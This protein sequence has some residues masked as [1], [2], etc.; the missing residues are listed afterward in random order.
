MTQNK[1]RFERSSAVNKLKL[2]TSG[3]VVAAAVLLAT[4]PQVAAAQAG[5]TASGH[6]VNGNPNI[7]LG[8]A[9]LTP[10]ATTYI[11]NV[12]SAE[13]VINWTPVDQSGT[14]PI[15][16]LP[17]GNTLQ[18]RGNSAGYTVLNRILPTDSSRA[19]RFDGIVQ[20]R[21]FDGAPTP[22]LQQS[23]N[24]W[25]YSPGG[26]IAGAGSVFDVGSLVLTTNDIDFGDGNL[27]GPN[28]EIRF[29]GAAGSLSSVVVEGATATLA[30]AS[31]DADN[32]FAGS[33]FGDDSYVA[34]VAPRVEQ[35]GSVNADGSVAY[36][37]AEQANL[38]I[39]GNN[40]FS[41]EIP[42]GAGT[43]DANGIVHSGVTGGTAPFENADKHHIYMVAVPKNQ[44]MT[45]LLSGT[46]GH[47]IAA[48]AFIEG[49][50]IILSAGGD[51]SASSFSDSV[52]ETIDPG[53]NASIAITGATFNGSIAAFANND[54]SLNATAGSDVVISLQHAF[55]DIEFTS[56]D[57]ILLSATGGG[58]FDFDSGFDP[59]RPQ[60]ITFNAVNRIDL[61]V[62]PGSRMDMFGNL[63]LNAFSDTQGGVVDLDITGSGVRTIGSGELN[64]DGTFNILAG[65][66]GTTSRGAPVDD[67]TDT[68][69]GTINVDITA[70]GLLDISGG[71]RFGRSIFD[72]SS[73]ANHGSVTG[74]DSFGGTTNLNIVGAGST[75]VAD[76]S[77]GLELEARGNS[78]ST[79]RGS[80]TGGSG[81]GGAVNLTVDGGTITAASLTA[82]AGADGSSNASNNTNESINSA[83]SGDVTATFTDA[84]LNVGQLSLNTGAAAAQSFDA[85]GNVVT[86]N[87]AG[88]DLA[89]TFDNTNFNGNSLGLNGDAF[90]TGNVLNGLVAAGDEGST[91]L[92]IRNGSSL[93]LTGDFNMSGRGSADA[94]GSSGS[95]DLNFLVDNAT[96]SASNITLTNSRTTRAPAGTADGT[97]GDVNFTV[98][99]SGS[100]TAGRLTLAAGAFNSAPGGQATAG[101]VNL[102]VDT[103]GV[104]TLTEITSTSLSISTSGIGSDNDGSTGDTT[105]GLGI[106]GNI[107][108][109]LQGGGTMTMGTADFT[110]DGLI[111]GVFDGQGVEPSGQ[112]GSGV[113][114]SV[115]F[116]LNG[117]TFTAT[118][119]TV[120]A[121]G[122]AS[123]GGNS[124]I[125]DPFLGIIPNVV[126][127][128][129]IGTG[130]DV[131]FNLRGTDVAVNN[132]TVAADGNGGG[133]GDSRETEGNPAGNGGQGIGGSASF[134]ANS[135]S[136]TVANTLTVS[137]GGFG[138][139]GGTGEGVDAGI[140]GNS[141]GGTAIF[142]LD[143]TAVVNA[144]TGGIIVSSNTTGGAGGNAL[145]GNTPSP[146][147]TPAQNSGDGGNAVAG[148]AT[149][150]N[151][152]GTIT[153]DDLN[154]T[155]VGT[156]GAAGQG[157][158]ITIITDPFTGS[159][160]EVFSPSFQG[161]NGAIGGN[162]TG[163]NATVNLNQDDPIARAYT[164][165]A[166]GIGASGSFGINGGDGG[167]GQGGTA[168]LNINN[169]S[170]N[171]S[172]ATIRATATGGAGAVGNGTGG[173]GG[174]GGDAIGGT[175]I[176]DVNGAA[177]ALSSSS[178]VTIIS[179]AAGGAGGA[180]GDN[181]I[182]SGPTG[183]GG[184][185]GDGTGGTIQVS[186]TGGA[187]LNYTADG[188]TN[189]TG[190]GGTGGAG[191][192]SPA[193]NVPGNGGAGGNGSGGNINFSSTGGS[194]FNGSGNSSDSQLS[195]GAVGGAGGLGGTGA[196]GT[197]G[198]T[199]NGGGAAGGNINLTVDGVGSSMI[200]A[201]SLRLDV[202]GV[203]DRTIL[204]SRV[205]YSGG[206]ASGGAVVI[207]VTDGGDFTVNGALAANSAALGGFGDLSSGSATGGNVDI[208]MSGAT[209]N[210]DLLGAFDPSD[211]DFNLQNRS[212]AIQTGDDALT[213]STTASAGDD[214]SGDVSINFTGGTANLGSDVNITTQTTVFGTNGGG[215]AVAGDVDLTFTGG[216]VTVGDITVLAGS[217]AGNGLPGSASGSGSGGN[218]T[219]TNT[220][221]LTIGA[222]NLTSR[223]QSGRAAGGGTAGDAIGGSVSFS[224]D[225]ALNGLTSL[226]LRSD[227]FGNTGQ[228]G[229]ATVDGGEGGSAVSGDIMAS[230][231]GTGSISP[232]DIALISLAIGGLGGAGGVSDG[233]T[234][235]SGANGGA[236]GDATAGNVIFTN[237]RTAD[238]ISDLSLISNA[239]A[240]GGGTGGL[241]DVGGDGGDG[242]QGQGGL[243]RVDL[244]GGGTVLASGAN[245][246]LSAFGFGG[247]GRAG[248]TGTGVT[249]GNGGD[250]GDGIG[251]TAIANLGNDNPNPIL[252]ALDAS[253]T[254][255]AGG[256]GLN[257]GDGGIGTGGL[258]ALNVIDATV[259][260]DDPSIIANGIGGNGGLGSIDPVSGNAGNSGSGGNAIGGTARLEVTG[261]N[262]NID[263]GF[264]DQQSNATGGDGGSG[265]YG[266]LV[267]GSGSGT[268]GDADGGTSEIV[269][270][271]GGTI[272][273]TS[274]LFSLTST[275]TGGQGGDGGGSYADTAADGSNGG[276]GTGGT[277]RLLAQG[278]TISGN[279][280]NITTT[281]QGGDAGIG[282]IYGG[283]GAGTGGPGVTGTG[284]TGI[285]GTATIEVQE[286]SPGIITL[287]NVVATANGTS[288][289]GGPAFAGFGGRIEITDSS[290]DPAGLIT[291]DSLTA[292]AFDTDSGSILFSNSTPL[293]GFYVTGDSGA[294]SVLGE[295]IVNV[296]GNIEYDFDGDSQM[297][298]GGNAVLNSGQNIL[299]NHTNN[300]TPVNSIDVSGTFD[301]NAEFDFIS[302]DG[303]RINSGG[304][305]TVRA[306]QDA[307]VADITGVG[308]VNISALQDVEVNNAAVTGTPFVVTLGT[309]S[310]AAAPQ[311]VINAGFDPTATPLPTYN[312]A[313]GA[314]ITG[315]VTSTGRIDISAGGIA[316]FQG[317]SNVISDN[318]LAVRAGDDIIVEAGAS[319]T[320][321]NAPSTAPNALFT[322]TNPGNL[323]LQTDNFVDIFGTPNAT[324]IGARLT[325][326][327]S[328]VA[329]GDLNAGTF[330]VVM[331]ANAIDGLGGTIN[332]SSFSADIND[333]P[334]NATIAG[335]GQ[336][337]DNG[338][339]SAQCVQG[340]SCFGTITADNIVQIGQNSNND[341]IQAIVEGG[342]IIA[343]IVRITTRN[344]IVMGTDGVATTIRA[345]TEFLAE[346]TE[347]DVNLRDASVSSDSVQ[348]SALNGS[349][350][351][352]GSLASLNSIG[353]D[354]GSSIN[355]AGIT[356]GG[357][358]A[359]TAFGTPGFYSI[360]GTMSVGSLTVGS[361]DINY[362]AG[363]SFIFGSISVPGTD[364]NLVAVGDIDIGSSLTASNINLDGF[365]ITLGSVSANSDINLLAASTIDFG[366]VSA[367]NLLDMTAVNISGD[368]A[369][370]NEVTIFAD[371]DVDANSISA[372][373]T[374]VVEAVNIT[375]GDASGGTVS[376]NGSDIV[377]GGVSG[378]SVDISGDQIS[379]DGAS[380]G[381]LSIGGGDISVGSISADSASLFGDAIFVDSAE[382]GELDIF[383]QT[384]LDVNLIDIDENAT[385]EAAGPMVIGTANTG[386]NASLLA[387]TVTLV[388][389]NVAGDL[390]MEATAG[391]IDGNGIVA[392]G[393]AIDLDATGDIGF[394][395]LSAGTTF[396]ANAGGAITFA[397][398]SAESDL[399]LDAA[400][401]ISGGDASSGAEITIFGTDLELGSLS[402]ESSARFGARDGNIAIDTVDINSSGLFGTATG[403]ITI[404][405]V[406]ASNGIRLEGAGGIEINSATST[407][408]TLISTDGDVAVREDAAF[409]NALTARGNSVFIRSNGSLKTVAQANVGD[410][411]IVTVG[412]LSVDDATAVGNIRLTSLTGSAELNDIITGNA[413]FG[414]SATGI[415]GQAT[416]SSNGNIDVTAALD[417]VINSTTNAANALTITAGNLIDI[418]AL[419]SGTTIDLSS[420]DISINTAGQLGIFDQTNDIFI[421]SN[422]IN[423]AILGGAGTTGVFSLS[424]AEF[425]RIQSNQDLTIFVA[426]TGGS[427]PDLIIQDLTIQTGDNVSGTQIATIGFSGALTI[428]S[429]QSTRVDGNLNLTNASS[430]TTLNL[431][432]V[433]DLR[434]NANGGVI[435]ITDASG[436]FG[437]VGLMTLTA[438]NIYAVT[439]QAFADIAGLDTNAV[440][441]RLE[442][443]DGIDID[444]GLIRGGI[445]QF[446]VDGDLFIQNTAPGVDFADRRGFSV[447]S[448]TISGLSAGSNANIVINGIVNGQTGIDTIFATDTVVGFDD[449]STINGCVIIDPSSCGA[450]PPT[451]TPTPAPTSDPEIDDPVQD[452]IEEEVTPRE[453]G[454]IVS[455]PFETNLIEIK[456]NEEYVDD[457]LIDE[458]VTGAGNDDL[459]VSDEDAS[460]DENDECE[461]GDDSCGE[462]GTVQ[463][464]ELEPAE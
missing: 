432:S 403:T 192:N 242:G 76:G 333:A 85:M 165:D 372:G 140:G 78:T 314:N 115:T 11:V 141:T 356:T 171:L 254:G 384:R 120:S 22:T 213:T 373:D 321:A 376:I 234:G 413:S 441:L 189:A 407:I 59:A 253:G 122:F 136:L 81:T 322:F 267:D 52:D 388:D 66:E 9:S 153:F 167:L 109:T 277:A 181:P 310:I 151:L 451:P 264:I 394:G 453:D 361:G 77:F 402:S 69:G 132:L 158:T 33:S 139:Q 229:A 174:A 378:G 90:G 386:G 24:I 119:L 170:V 452:V 14:D 62:G 414:T 301:A 370:G 348:I 232:T 431:T 72:A 325:P 103:A 285:G 152:S 389:G 237:N 297:T 241:G 101:N 443:N 228:A 269:A 357:E 231:A 380:A 369:D 29:R 1:K 220:G 64:V 7:V 379:I 218:I 426:S 276:Q 105:P 327:S 226:D 201:Q 74:A 147:P 391:D 200:F 127:D 224:S 444:D 448:L 202:R 265:E 222:V 445:A 106:G 148:T 323:V 343:D 292:D 97:P 326:I 342:S 299:I 320:A 337:D 436:S 298:V 464:D 190:I 217:R 364:I 10:G 154:V 425:T 381:N 61:D 223:G 365:D 415:T 87:A 440:D 16:F 199:G 184:A 266:F 307:T 215:N 306:E 291:L 142:N 339:L 455:D 360:T 211:P 390:S 50:K 123:D 44:A 235:A 359:R 304:T 104:L 272:N 178:I 168:S 175:S 411:D 149:F 214:I 385:L 118:D 161:Q 319:L 383:A 186:A 183:A 117:S 91:T 207:A 271:T 462:D 48:T 331:S 18:F 135:G 239:F 169:A 377:I 194:T 240:S 133:G 54:I 336:L 442:N 187:T 256:D 280:V 146:T 188:L 420:A 351:G 164:V 12:N 427:T 102:L 281:G 330:A 83:F 36:V 374:L 206:D 332:A 209:S 408:G 208:S 71:P 282:G 447:D 352:S 393:G 434:I 108:V 278:G 290:T 155:A 156:G 312:R 79:F 328:I 249:P 401:E 243:T 347:G 430:G 84:T 255:A 107:D 128:G 284:G 131:T 274:G 145:V 329:A 305:A 26:I 251:G 367:G 198:D 286:G 344:D 159:D 180:G 162:G 416:T 422:G 95:A 387:E 111:A 398:A 43:G 82:D 221:N 112:G 300:A 463:E 345:N 212:L 406:T 450:P 177:G 395:S 6:A 324:S 166:S 2:L 294:M 8:S 94:D 138:G 30:A 73:S 23:G 397:G 51:V 144:G 113:G 67:G 439:D 31:I 248:A 399:T 63:E 46:I 263:L 53:K 418:Q 172:S 458:P 233:T 262:G 96:F 49:S 433:D 143:G 371:F 40:L 191:G 110:G 293:G 423:Q 355:A 68:I 366:S 362:D 225:G 354:V 124:T 5:P 203:A 93:A 99:N 179:E 34:I 456:D 125:D 57:S 275:G 259:V 341:T 3:S 20:G 216:V 37:A 461:D 335:A 409:S 100:V 246:T 296:V 197:F 60:G 19:I 303:S 334:T 129:G 56:G 252:V 396:D 428:D 317:G 460:G 230:L 150:S 405:T 435:Q 173:N 17:E 459:W 13:S 338:L 350:L 315:D 308:L 358:L 4:T 412:N 92:N 288:G 368:V 55:T 126:G 410:I 279:D 42:V 250:G 196:A 205:N 38:T 429:G 446:I 318:G 309:I 45:M 15:N 437:G 39:N 137:S 454:S 404:D 227:A 340:N 27:F 245:V 219:V 261:D 70:G 302:T 160:I 157:G 98:Q 182:G 134:N 346:S 349:L 65:V 88:G 273:L 438:Q 185:G 400:A 244:S 41:I 163:G 363:G 375:I 193:F 116:N 204:A 449:P 257:G 86:A 236:G 316:F 311:L 260:F 382:G 238:A 268:G 130:G 392:V 419:A 25:F 210:F 295:L 258:A 289:T 417:V 47:D 80:S 247:V 421:E 32:F 353:I 89:V 75:L 58:I 287:G 176:L 283:F 424:E 28:Q 114:G 35:G 313:F 195:S 457:P 121:S 270:R 21:S